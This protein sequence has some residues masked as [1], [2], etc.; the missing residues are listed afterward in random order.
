MVKTLS[1]S[2]LLLIPIFVALIMLPNF[3]H[4]EIAH[5]F[6]IINDMLVS[7]DSNNIYFFEQKIRSPTWIPDTKI[8]HSNSTDTTALSENL[9]V[10]P[11]EINETDENLVFATL[12][13]ECIGNTMC[14]FQDIITMSKNDGTYKKIIQSMKS[15]I[16][17]SLDEN[18]IYLSESSGKIWKYTLDGKDGQLLYEGNG[19][20]IMDIIVSNGIV[21]WIEE[22]SDQNSQILMLKNGKITKIAENLQIPYKLSR[23]DKGI[24]WHDIRI[25]P[26][27]NQV[28]EYTRFS[29]YDGSVIQT[30]AEY[31]NKTPLSTFA[32]PVYGPYSFL[33]DFLFVTNNTANNAT[34]TLIDVKSNQNYPIKTV[35]DYD[36]LYFR[37]NHNTLYVVGQDENGFLIEKLSLP[38]SVPEFSMIFVL[39]SV[40]IG[41][42]LTVVSRRIFHY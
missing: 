27:N 13:D 29:T 34:I 42:S 37:N 4:A 11:T 21:Y 33:G 1:S 39:F 17:I 18:S 41:L 6:G 36:V 16:Q 30:L 38:V 9:F 19:I 20:I 26:I 3:T 23:H 15:A 2:G 25:G 22:I 5:G 24:A 31:N 28:T 40:T 32:K 8:I 7:K 10:Y 35:N 12:S 14:D